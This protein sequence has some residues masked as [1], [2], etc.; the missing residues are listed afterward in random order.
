MEE[1]INELNGKIAEAADMWFRVYRV[2]YWDR[3]DVSEEARLKGLQEAV[4]DISFH[5]LWGLVERKR[6]A[7]LDIEKDV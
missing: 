5:A 2:K 7:E 6:I 4:S 3:N 1:N